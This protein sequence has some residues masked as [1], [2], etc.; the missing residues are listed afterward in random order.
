MINLKLNILLENLNPKCKYHLKDNGE[1]FC[2]RAWAN[3]ERE[4]LRYANCDG[5]ILKCELNDRSFLR[6]VA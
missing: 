5:G 2:K 4:V 1:T 3:T 6:R